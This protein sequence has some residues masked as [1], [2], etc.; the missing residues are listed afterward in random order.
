MDTS[1]WIAL[2]TCVA[3]W[4][5]LAVYVAL[6]FYA[7]GQLDEYRTQRRES[8][9]P[10]VV[11]DFAVDFILEITVANLGARPARALRFS[12]SEP[13]TS[14]LKDA[15]AVKSLALRNGIPMLPPGKRYAFVWDSAPARF[16]DGTLCMTYE[17]TVSYVDDHGTAY[18]DTYIL[19]LA[20]L[21]DASIERAP[22]HGVV[23][24]I[25]ELRRETHKW[26]DGTRGLLVHS[27][28]KDAMTR[29]Q[30]EE[31][32]AWRVARKATDAAS[33]SDS[34]KP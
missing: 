23:K 13:L 25:D 17:V 6:G 11:V 28:D 8:L 26:T 21:S 29:M 18:Q 10:Y 20:S 9:R 15:Q 3:A 14:T 34:D 31:Y 12:F 24:A 1:T 16:A 4:L 33:H 27:R 30:R 7:K 5:T 19:D 22:W 32:E 2:A